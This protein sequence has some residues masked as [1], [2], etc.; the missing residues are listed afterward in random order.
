MSSRTDPVRPWEDDDLRAWRAVVRQFFDREV[1]PHS[2][3]WRLDHAVPRE[4]WLKAGEVGL[5]LCG[6]PAEYGGGG[7]SFAHELVV[8]EELARSLDTGFGFG[9][10]SPVVADYL[11]EYGSEQQKQKFLPRMASGEVVGSIAMTEPGA[12]TDLRALRTRAARVE[13]GWTLSGTK[14]FITNGAVAGMVIVVAVTDPEAGSRSLSLFAVDTSEPLTGFT[15]SAQFRKIGQTSADTV[16]LSFDDVHLPDDSLIGEVGAGLGYLMGQLP[17]ERLVIA[18]AAAA[19]TGRAVELA[20]EYTKE[21]IVFG[22]P[23]FAMQNTRFE[24]AECATLAE[25]GRT[26][27]DRLIAE[28][29]AG[30]LT[31]ASASMAKYWLTDVQ[32]QVVDRCLQLFGGYGYMEEYPIARMFVDARVQRIYGG[33]NE[34]MKEL[35]ARSL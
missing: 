30:E 6:A 8:V 11:V 23:L 21:R 26:F 27:I 19:A 22:A 16:E 7:G 31:A 28:H 12:G 32:G 18:A 29:V 14:T 4:L 24:L 20:V 3:Q 5:L 33:A 15:R 25:I 13:G 2:E 1:V 34:V 35:I 17:R 10:H 9:V